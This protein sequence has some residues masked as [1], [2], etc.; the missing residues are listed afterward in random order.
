MMK[1]ILMS[2]ALLCILTTGARAAL[3]TG[4]AM[5]Q[6]G[7]PNN[8]A[9]DLRFLTAAVDA[10][11]NRPTESRIDPFCTTEIYYRL[12]GTA[13]AGSAGGVA[14]TFFRFTTAPTSSTLLL[15]ADV[16][17]VVAHFGAQNGGADIMYYI[18]GERGESFTLS[19]DNSWLRLGGLSSVTLFGSGVNS[20][21]AE[22]TSDPTVPD[23]GTT[24]AMFGIGL[25]GLYTVGRCRGKK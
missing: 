8:P 17:Y 25:C 2:L 21:T 22:F 11:N 5:V 16:Q 24:L 19:A 13:N 3:I 1:K 9:D 23:G 12:L 18:N 14:S 15:N 20:T 4:F 10:W 7:V 6:D